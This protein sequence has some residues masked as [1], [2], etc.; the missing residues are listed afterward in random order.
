MYRLERAERHSGSNRSYFLCCLCVFG[1][2][3]CHC[4]LLI[5]S[6]LYLSESLPGLNSSSFLSVLPAVLNRFG[7][8]LRREGVH[9]QTRARYLLHLAVLAYKQLARS[10]PLQRRRRLRSHQSLPPQQCRGPNRSKFSERSL[11]L[12][13]LHRKV[14]H[15]LQG[16]PI[17]RQIHRNLL[18]LD[19]R[20]REDLRGC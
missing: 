6:G 18:E 19:L 8:P 11:V 13:S 2:R 3:V 12:G 17:L 10:S 4:H 16:H 14:L 9:L 1:S 15:H 20:S 7:R 5:W